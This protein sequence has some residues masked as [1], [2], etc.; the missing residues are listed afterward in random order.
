LY[1]GNDSNLEVGGN[2]QTD[3]CSLQDYKKVFFKSND[4]LSLRKRHT[5]THVDWWVWKNRLLH[6]TNKWPL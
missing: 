6:N 4:I 5:G 3:T 1:K 2:M